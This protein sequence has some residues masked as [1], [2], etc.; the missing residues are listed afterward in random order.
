[1]GSRCCG[2]GQ[3]LDSE[4]HCVGKPS[5]CGEILTPTAHGCEAPEQRIF[6]AGGRLQIGPSDWEAQGV[7]ES[8]SIEVPSFWLDRFEVSEGRWAHC[9]KE[10]ACLG[11][12]YP[13]DPGRAAVLSL[14]QSIAFCRWA[15]GRLPLD[16]EWTFA[17][18]GL[19]GNRYPWGNTGAVCRRAA[20]GLVAGPCG[21]GARGPDTVGARPD[22]NSP[23]GIADLAGNV[24]EWVVV[25]PGHFRLRG[26]SFRSL[27]AS[28]LRGWNG[29]P[30]QPSGDT[31]V[32]C[33]YDAP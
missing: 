17:V 2:V 26:G 33:A 30:G 8:R 15:G 25:D 5:H 20:Y 10:G 24:A 23:E 3:Q 27:L 1:M 14:E 12:V 19:L 6:L 11:E 31:G 29:Q 7:V 32:R 21:E 9:V 4:M 13:E 16:D 18:L 28:E 22:G